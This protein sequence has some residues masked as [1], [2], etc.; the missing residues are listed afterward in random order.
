MP[1][2][3]Y[4]GAGTNAVY[5]IDT[6]TGSLLTIHGQGGQDTVDIGDGY[7]STYDGDVSVDNTQTGSTNLI[8][9]DSKVTTRQNIAFDSDGFTD[10]TPAM[11]TYGTGVTKL[12]LAGGTGGNH[13]DLD[14]DGTPS[15]LTT[16]IDTG[17]ARGGGK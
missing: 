4:T 3:I 6:G 2:T 17:V 14:I 10:L 12:T 16:T 5:V 13:V 15:T 7:A 1:T 8:V 9:D 11:I